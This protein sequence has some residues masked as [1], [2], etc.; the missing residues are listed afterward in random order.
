MVS[1]DRKNEGLAIG[2][3]I[4]E[5][6]TL[7]RIPAFFDPN[8]LDKEAEGWADDMAVK[9]NSVGQA[10]GNLSGGNQQNVAIARLLYHDADVL[11]LDE[12]TRGIDVGSKALIYQTIDRL[13]ARENKAILMVS[14]YLPELLGV[15]DRIAVM[16]RGVLR[17]ARPVAE[18]DE[19]KIMQEATGTNDMERNG[20]TEA[21]GTPQGGIA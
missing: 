11:L 12:P 8:L 21:P 10:I 13:A 16:S 15:C 6:M 18:W 17:P 20:Q 14:S 5:N 9:R 2:L 1:E 7:T 19:R 3:S 4:T